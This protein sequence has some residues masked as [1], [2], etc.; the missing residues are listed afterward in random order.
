MISYCVAINSPSTAST[1][2]YGLSFMSDAINSFAVKTLLEYTLPTL[3]PFHI[4]P[5]SGMFGVPTTP[6]IP[7]FLSSNI[8]RI[9]SSK[10]I[11]TIKTS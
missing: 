7:T 11:L 10:L 1:S 5:F 9:S 4:Q 8:L 2:I 3:G 6:S